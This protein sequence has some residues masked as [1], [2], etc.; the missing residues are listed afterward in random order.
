[1][2][3]RLTIRAHHTRCQ[4]C[5][6]SEDYAV[7]DRYVC[8]GVATW[9]CDD[10]ACDADMDAPE[11]LMGEAFEREIPAPGWDFEEICSDL[12]QACE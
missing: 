12:A 5:Q 7:I 1:M 10:C 4:F 9:L 6:A 8:N 2:T 11:P 3:E